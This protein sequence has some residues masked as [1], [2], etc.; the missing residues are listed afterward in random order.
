M[1]PI[2]TLG[3]FLAKRA[4]GETYQDL[5]GLPNSPSQISDAAVTDDYPITKFDTEHVFDGIHHS[6][7]EFPFSLNHS[8]ETILRI[9]RR[10]FLISIKAVPHHWQQRLLNRLRRSK[11]WIILRIELWQLDAKWR[12]ERHDVMCSSVVITELKGARH[13]E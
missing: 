5:L 7:C 12:R 9:I 2:T 8:T 11:S 6:A 10:N 3:M 1:G 4:I 13:P